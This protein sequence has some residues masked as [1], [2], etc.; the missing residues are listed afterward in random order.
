MTDEEGGEIELTEDSNGKYNFI[1]PEGKAK[2]EVVFEEDKPVENYYSDIASNW[3]AEDINL[4]ADLGVVTGK[5]DGTFRPDSQITRA[6]IVAILVRLYDLNS[7]D[8]V[9]LTTQK[10]TGRAGTFRLRRLWD[11]ST[12]LMRSISDQTIS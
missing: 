8:M 11:T 6:E 4:L 3:A 9:L 5:P 12:V 7:D 1:M 2:L 10:I